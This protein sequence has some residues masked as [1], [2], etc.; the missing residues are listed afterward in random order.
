MD[1]SEEIKE[2]CVNHG[3]LPVLLW[4]NKNWSS[5][6]Y[7]SEQYEVNR[8]YILNYFKTS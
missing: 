6:F 7:T 8:T 5:K 2:A 1:V 4:N 3:R